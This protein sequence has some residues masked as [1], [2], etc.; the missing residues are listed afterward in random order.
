MVV[1]YDTDR[2]NPWVPYPVSRDRL[3]R[4]L[5]EAGGW[6]IEWLGSR[7]SRY[8]RAPI[9]AANA[10]FTNAIDVKYRD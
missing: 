7:P 9:Y 6:A 10:L 8:Q 3:R 2:A 1:E 5:D 4:L